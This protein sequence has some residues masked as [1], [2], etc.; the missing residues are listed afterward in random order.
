MLDSKME[1]IRAVDSGMSHESA[2]LQF[3]IHRTTVTKIIKK[4][5]DD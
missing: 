5:A 3:N 2:A 1:V 4:S